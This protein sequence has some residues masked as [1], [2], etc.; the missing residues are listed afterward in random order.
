MRR[1]VRVVVLLAALIIVNVSMPNAS[2]AARIVVLF[3][4]ILAGNLAY[5]LISNRG[6]G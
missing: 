5:R 6:S 2:M 4:I 1:L 3:V